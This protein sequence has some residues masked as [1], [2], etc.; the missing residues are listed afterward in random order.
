M[1]T[2]YEVTI[3]ATIIKRFSIKAQSS[4]EATASATEIWKRQG[5][6]NPAEASLE[7]HT[8]GSGNLNFNL[9]TENSL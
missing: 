7:I 9:K 6:L 4:A 5:L 2:P 1:K 8:M 3:K